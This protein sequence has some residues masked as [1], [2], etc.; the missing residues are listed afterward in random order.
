MP[1]PSPGKDFSKIPDVTVPDQSISLAEMIR[2]FTRNE[3]LPVGQKVFYMD[4][5]YD[6][7]KVA[8]M[9]LVDKEA[10]IEEQ[11]L[12]SKHWATQETKK[13]AALKEKQRQQAIADAKAELAADSA[14]KAK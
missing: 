13:A 2:R 11:K 8:K 3:P 6:L 12:V 1:K 5:K 9:D 14:A 7:E 4:T 10:F